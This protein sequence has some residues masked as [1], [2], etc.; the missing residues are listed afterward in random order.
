MLLIII[1]DFIFSNKLEVLELLAPQQ[2]AEIL[3]LNLPTLPDKDVIINVVFDFL[4]Q[5]SQEKKFSGF[6]PYLVV[7]L[8]QVNNIK[9]FLFIQD[10]HCSQFVSNTFYSPSSLR[11]TFPVRRTKYCK[12]KSKQYNVF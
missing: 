6:L 3:E 8:P 2:I 12:C 5:S 10:L 11:Q 9:H 7:S 4:T 1:N